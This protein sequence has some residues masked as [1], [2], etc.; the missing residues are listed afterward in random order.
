MSASPAAGARPDGGYPL[1]SQVESSTEVASRLQEYKFYY[2]FAL[3]GGGTG[4]IAMRGD[5]PLP[6]NFVVNECFREVITAP[7]SAAHTAT[8]AITSG[9][10]AGDLLAA[11]VVSNSGWSTVT[12]TRA[13]ITKKMTAAH[14]PSIVVAVQAL[15]A[16]KFTIYL[17]G[18]VAP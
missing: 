17:T 7:D 10:A 18:H 9:E 6:I 2:D 4:T 3:D 5:T 13:Q 1:R 16:G 8:I 15:T 12:T 11:L 14:T